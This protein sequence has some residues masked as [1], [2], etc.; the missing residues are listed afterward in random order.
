MKTDKKLL[1]IAFSRL[2]K[3][4]YFA[5]QNFWCCQTCGRYAVPKDKADKMVF[6]HKQ[7][8]E[9]IKNGTIKDHGL[10]LAWEG[11]GKEITQVFLDVGL[12]A[13]WNGDKGT[14]ICINTQRKLG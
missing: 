3:M 11:N 6:Y 4:G 1:N 8:A 7:D 9:A 14:R 10:Y 12:D 2:R 5:K 13:V